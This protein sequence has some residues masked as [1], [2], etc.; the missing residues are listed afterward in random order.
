MESVWS[1]TWMAR[2][3]VLSDVRGGRN[4]TTLEMHLEDLIVL[5]SRP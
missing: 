2:S 5:T 3:S 4:G 1:C